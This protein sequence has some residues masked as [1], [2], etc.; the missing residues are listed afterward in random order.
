M[1]LG[2]SDLG[3][4]AFVGGLLAGEQRCGRRVKDNRLTR[5]A[6]QITNTKHSCLCH[7]RVGII[8][9]GVT[10]RHCKVFNKEP[11]SK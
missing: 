5:V 7:L 11:I 1:G 2:S 9:H 3:L 4:K 8:K 10:N 6:I